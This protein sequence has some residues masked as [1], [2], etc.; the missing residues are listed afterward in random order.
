MDASQS[1]RDLKLETANPTSGLVVSVLP[2][3]RGR[4]L[5][6]VV[7]IYAIVALAGC[8][9]GPDYRAPETATRDA[10]L[11]IENSALTTTEAQD[12]NWWSIFNDRVLDTLVDVALQ[13]NLSLQIAAVRIIEARAV[14]GISKGFRFPQ[15]QALSGQAARA[16]VSEN[17]PNPVLAG[18]TFSVYDVGFD[19]IWE[20]DF[21]GRFRR[22]I[23]A[24]DAEYL[25]A[26]AGYDDGV[27]TV[28]AEVA[29]V[30]VLLRTFEERLVLAIENVA[31]QTESLRIA[32]VRYR[33]G[34]V[35]ELDVTQARALLRD[36]EALIPVLETGLQQAKNALSTL[37]GRPPAEQADLLGT[38]SDI[39]TAPPEVAVGVPLNLLR[40]RPDIRFAEMQ[41]AAQSARIGIAQSDLYPRFT[42][43]GSIGLQTSD[44]GGIASSRNADFGDLFD[45]DS[46]RYSVG[47][48]FS[49]PIF[50]YGR[51]KNNVRVQDARFQQA[52]LNYQNAVLEAAQEVEDA[53]ASYLRNQTRARLLNDSVASA[54]RSVELALVQYREGSVNYQRVLDTQRFLV[55]Q[56]DQYTATRGD[57]GLSLIATYKALGGGWETRAGR[58]ILNPETE[59]E[60]RERT[61]WGEMLDTAYPAVSG[62][63]EETQQ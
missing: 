3:L 56:Q 18:N 5:I 46:L 21:W 7:V 1:S 39:P 57:V 11:E 41:A 6:N 43:F 60:M 62:T 2:E 14:L 32:E 50:N 35:T 19:S 20:I 9:I 58:P 16:S 47:P 55:Q 44:A 15:Q 23:E 13:D 59:A 12:N 28:I 51:I 36:T 61:N 10:W 37:I 63:Q 27:V 40:R 45:S 22:G 48:S 26:I 54:E 24:A 17:S 53:L 33:N 25:S 42:L 4:S 52:A 31:I 30:Y 49:W 29:R 34:A 8:A 38:G